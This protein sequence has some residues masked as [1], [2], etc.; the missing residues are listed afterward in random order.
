MKLWLDRLSRGHHC[1]GDNETTKDTYD[2]ASGEREDTTEARVLTSA[3]RRADDSL[4][5]VQI[6]V[7]AFNVQ[8]RGYLGRFCQL[9]VHIVD[10]REEKGLAER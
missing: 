3:P 9:V 1:M 4:R 8:Q 5:A 6:G 7:E 2:R 10:S